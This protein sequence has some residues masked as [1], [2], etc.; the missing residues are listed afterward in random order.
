VC[1]RGV[2]AGTTGLGGLVVGGDVEGDEQDQVGADDA[3]TSHPNMGKCAGE[4]FAALAGIGIISSY[5]VLFIS[6]YIA[7]V[8]AGTTGLGGLVVGGDV[9]GDEQD[10]VGADDADISRVHLLRFLHLLHL[11]LLPVAP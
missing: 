3:D 1:R 5:L 6:F 8:A 2:A 4:E 10:Q 11:C 9:E 7:S